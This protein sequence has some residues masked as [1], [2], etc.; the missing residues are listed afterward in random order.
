MFAKKSIPR[1]F[2]VLFVAV[3]LLALTFSAIGVTPA[4]AATFTVTN[5]NDSGAGSLREAVNAANTAAGA[6]TITFSVSGTITLE[7]TLPDIEDAAG[8][9]M[10]GTGQTLTVS[11]NHAVRIMGVG[12]GASL[13]LNNLT[14]ANGNSA[15][16]SGIFNTSGSTVTITNSTFSGNSSTNFGGGIYNTGGTL[17]ITNSTFSGNSA[18]ELGG[19]IDTSGTATITNSTFSGNSAGELGGGIYNNTGTLAITNSTFSGNSATVNG[20]GIFRQT[21]TVTL[22]NSIVANSTTGG[23][24]A[25]AITNSGDNL[26][27]GTTCGWG[28]ASGSMSSTDPLLGALANN[29]GPTQTFALFTGSPAID[30]GNDTVCAAAVGAPDYGAGGFDQRGV[31]RPQ[32]AGGKCDIGAYEMGN[33]VLVL[34]SPSNGATLHYNRPT[35]DWADFY[36]A[37]GYQI[38][39]SKNN[40]FTLSVVNASTSAANSIYTPTSNLPANTLL[41]WRVRAKLGTAKSAWSDVWTFHTGSPPSVPSV[42]SPADNALIRDLTPLLD[43]GKSSGATFDHYQIQLADNSGF[44]GA[45][46]EDIAGASNHAY[47]PTVDLNPNIK[48][49]WH[50]HSWNTAGDYSAWSALRTFREAMLPPG[51]VGPIGGITVVDRKPALDWDDVIGATKYTLQ[52]STNSSFTSL[53]L[54]LNVTPSTYTPVSNLAVNRLFY[55][56]VKT[57]GPNGPSAW[58]AVETFHTP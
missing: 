21:G 9:T 32:P 30:A 1:I 43:W 36:G 11:G 50:V 53:V 51:L 28:S 56:R 57:L 46:D 42:L 23:N 58:S 44:A 13:T 4:H 19:G 37:T 16:G 47:T 8:L 3:T 48:Y 2:S 31:A 18:G 52:V 55:W 25:G 34:L 39:V 45:V 6:D 20:G 38:Q 29:G 12:V 5:L 33:S 14:I 15:S 22:S 27:S 10:D 7:S 35:F 49:Y 54:N 26:D 40:S 24:C 17:A 41:Y